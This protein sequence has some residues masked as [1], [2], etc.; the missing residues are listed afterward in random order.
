[1]PRQHSLLLKYQAAYRTLDKAV[2]TPQI[3]LAIRGRAKQ[4]FLH[5][6]KIDIKNNAIGLKT[7]ALNTIA[8]DCKLHNTKVLLPTKAGLESECSR[9]YHIILR[10]NSQRLQIAKFS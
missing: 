2:R 6:N 7:V 8:F 9:S 1:M 3:V 4:Q 5:A 10:T